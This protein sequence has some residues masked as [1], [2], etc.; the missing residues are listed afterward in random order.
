[1]ACGEKE[2]CELW[3]GVKKF[4]PE[5]VDSEILWNHLGDENI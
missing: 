5:H 1:M 3:K 2:E 4:V